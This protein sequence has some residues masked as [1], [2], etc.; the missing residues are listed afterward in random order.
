MFEIISRKLWKVEDFLQ[1]VNFSLKFNNLF[2]RKIFI[3]NERVLK[4]RTKRLFFS[5]KLHIKIKMIYVN[6]PRFYLLLGF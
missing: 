2:Q 6:F 3:L 4:E 1:N 5:H